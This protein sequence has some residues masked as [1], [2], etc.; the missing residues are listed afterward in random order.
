MAATIGDWAERNTGVVTGIF[1]S[2]SL[3]INV[4]YQLSQPRDGA[5]SYVLAGASALS[6][7]VACAATFALRNSW[8]NAEYGLALICLLAL[9][10]TTVYNLSNAVGFAGSSRSEISGTRTSRSTEVQRLQ[11][12]DLPAKQ[13]SRETPAKTAAGKTP[14]MAEADLKVLEQDPRWTASDKCNAEKVVKAKAASFCKGYAEKSA[15]LVAAKEV[16]RIDKE[17][18]D[19]TRQIA[20]KGGAGVVNQPADTQAASIAKAFSLV[21]VE[22][23]E[24]EIGDYLNF[25]LGIVIEIIGTFGPIVAKTAAGGS[26]PVPVPASRTVAEAPVARETPVEP[27]FRAARDVKDEPQ[28]L[29]EPAKAVMITPSHE[30]ERPADMATPVVDDTGVA[31]GVAT[32]VPFAPPQQKAKKGRTSAEQTREIVREFCESR[33]LTKAGGKIQAGTLYEAFE[34]WLQ[35]KGYEHVTNAAFGRAMSYLGYQKTTPSCNRTFYL[36][37]ALKGVRLA[38]VNG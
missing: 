5:T 14:A 31:T 22:V 26:A 37:I 1:A 16:E 34:A 19:L 29:E 25:G 3:A 23:G 13:N 7:I 27:I 10:G 6:V 38:V 33:L 17:I 24:K 20:E 12:T 28:P 30:E 36:N 4:Y 35:D 15:I 32:V 11:D 18:A 8:R 9:L 2:P 21:H